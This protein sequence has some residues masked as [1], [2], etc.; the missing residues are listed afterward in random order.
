MPISKPKIK[1]AP[2]EGGALP[3]RLP[4]TSLSDDFLRAEADRI[5][6]QMSGEFVQ[7]REFSGKKTDTKNLANR[8]KVEVE[9]L[10]QMPYT[11]EP[12]AETPPVGVVTHKPGDVIMGIPGDQTIAHHELVDLN[13]RPLAD[14][15]EQQGGSRYGLTRRELENPDFWASNFGAAR[16]LQNKVNRVADEFGTGDIYGHHLAMGMQANNFAQHFADANLKAI[17]PDMSL[18]G[19]RAFNRAVAKGFKAPSGERVTFP[20]FPGIRDRDAAYEAMQNNPEMRKWFNNRMKIG[21]MPGKQVEWAITEPEL[22]NMEPSVTGHSVG[23]MAPGAELIPGGDHATYDTRI[24]GVHLGAAPA[25]APFEVAF[26]DATAHV[27]AT[28][29]PTDFTGTIQKISPHQVVD[30][31][32][33][34]TMGKYYE[35]LDQAIR[36]PKGF[37][38]GGMVDSNDPAV[39]VLKDGVQDPDAAEVLNLDLA[40]LA[41]MGQQPQ[42]NMATGGPVHMKRAG[43]V[44]GYRDPVTTKAEVSVERMRRELEKSNG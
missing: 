7:Q 39:Q 26:P 37:A 19:I 22:R 35:Y 25:L 16:N 43:G 5:A 27:Q 36:N 3:M 10:S 13:G 30:Q 1:I 17:P 34:D 21:E 28:Q 42:Q 31:Q 24:P 9:R 20:D 41:L 14:T 6:R 40:K 29:H 18:S 44:K 2:S 38:E 8:S 15:S 23:R 12:T 4:R 32:W 33:V 11:L